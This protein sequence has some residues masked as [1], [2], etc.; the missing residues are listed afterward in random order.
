MSI[1]DYIFSLI[2]VAES[3]FSA[4]LFLWLYRSSK[5]KQ[6]V[7]LSIF[8]VFLSSFYLMSM[9]F[10]S[11]LHQIIPVLY[12]LSLP[13]T[14]SILPSFYIYL[15][16][17]TGRSKNHSVHKLVHYAPAVIFFWMLMM[18]WFEP[19]SV[20]YDYTTGNLHDL[21]DL[22]LLNF[23][24]LVY[25]IGVY[26]VIHAQFVVYFILLL[27]ELRRCRRQIENRYSLNEQ[28]NL[29]GITYFVL[30]FILL[31]ILITFSHFLG[32]SIYPVSRVIFNTMSSG[33]IIFLLIRGLRFREMVNTEDTETD[34]V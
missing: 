5:E 27:F 17:I 11:G 19:A 31:Y 29:S 32:V 1:I 21:S 25:R 28:M 18:F 24:R 9:L 6:H 26:T 33:I 22:P 15:T 13:V 12:V 34:K 2:P 3:I 20:Q 10:N 30:F 8:F 14:L 23:I 4:V 16:S 7:Q